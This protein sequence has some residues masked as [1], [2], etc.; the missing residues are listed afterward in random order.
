MQS[1]V[2]LEHKVRA[3]VLRVLV[4]AAALLG[5]DFVAGWLYRGLTGESFYYQVIDPDQG[6]NRRYRATSKLYHHDLRPNVAA[7]AVW[8]TDYF[9]YTNSL[10]FRDREVRQVPLI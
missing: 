6:L 2:E 8:G 5:T 1:R 10:G 4:V 7:P 3:V 9:V